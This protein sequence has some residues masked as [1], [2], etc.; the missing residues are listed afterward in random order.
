MVPGGSD[1]PLTFRLLPSPGQTAAQRAK[2]MGRSG[3]TPGS[4]PQGGQ[5]DTALRRRAIPS[6]GFFFVKRH[7]DPIPRRTPPDKSSSRGTAGTA[8]PPTARPR[9]RSRWTP[10][11]GAHPHPSRPVARQSASRRPVPPRPP[12]QPFIKVDARPLPSMSSPLH[13]WPNNSGGVAHARRGRHPQ[14]SRPLLTRAADPMDASRPSPSDAHADM[15]ATPRPDLAS[16]RAP[17]TRVATAACPA[18]LRQD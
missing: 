18:T 8:W 15:P 12:P 7:A 11:P 1:T 16:Q 17:P 10:A 5:I 14:M 3:R 4:P 6:R 2:G 13:P 9:A